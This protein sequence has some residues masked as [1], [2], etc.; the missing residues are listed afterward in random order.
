MK[1]V[2]IAAAIALSLSAC[3]GT[4]KQL[5]VKDT[6]YVVLDDRHFE[7]QPVPRPTLTREE[8]K[9]LDDKAKIKW[10]T[11]LYIETLG[12]V[13]ILEKQISGIKKAMLESQEK[14]NR[15]D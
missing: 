14:L 2:I 3:T 12:H 1:S 4:P 6:Q 9:G 8:A 15:K 11:E 13:T 5:L 10:L 7:I